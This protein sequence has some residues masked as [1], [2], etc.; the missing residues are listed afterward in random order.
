V[1]VAEE[2]IEQAGGVVGREAAAVEELGEI[3]RQAKEAAYGGAPGKIAAT[4]Q[5][6]ASAISFGASDVALRSAGGGDVA[7][8]L[9]ETNPGYRLAGEA[10]GSLLG[11]GAKIGGAVAK[12]V[13]GITGKLVGA[14]TEGYLQGA[15]SGVSKTFLAEDDITAERLLGNVSSNALLGGGI[16]VGTATAGLGVEKLLRSARKGAAAVEARAGKAAAGDPTALKATAADDILSYHSTAREDGRWLIADADPKAKAALTKADRTLRGIGDTPDSFRA[17]PGQA[18][19]ALEKEE[20]ALTKIRDTRE[21]GLAKLADE[22][23]AIGAEVRLDLETMPTGAAETTFTGKTAQRYGAWAD[24]RVKGK[25]PQVKVTR[26][27]AAQFANAI[28]AGEVQGARAQAYAKLDDSIAR[29]QGL[30]TQLAE[31]VKPAAVVK[32][33]F[34]EKAVSGTIF[35]A[36][37]GAIPAIPFGAVVAPAI[38]AKVS[39][40][41]T[42]LLFRRAGGAVGSAAAGTAKALDVLMGAAEQVNK[43]A[44]PLSSKVLTSVR[45]GEEER[46]GPGRPKKDAVA[47]T[48]K[49]DREQLASAFRAREKELRSQVA[50]GP[51]GVTR[52][53]P[54]ARLKVGEHLMPIKQVQPKLADMVETVAARRVEF[55]ASKLPKRPDYLAMQFGPD[56]WRPSSLEMR[57][58]ARYVAAAEGP[59]AV[60]DRLAAGRLSPEDAE[61]Y[62]AIYPERFEALKLDVIKR[63]PELQKQ[64]PF[65]KRVALSMFTG[66]PLVPALRPE[67]LRVLQGGYTEEPGTDGGMNAPAANPAFGSVSREQPTPAQSRGGG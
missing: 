20:I 30:R 67:I 23:V 42:D 10:V 65:D 22:D 35:G 4:A 60:E 9:A 40:A 15:G 14:G 18:A 34:L 25:T 52:M 13:G 29:V 44:V 41:I 37:V 51:D 43:V 64:L 38:G 33:S 66:V 17:S 28:E 36:T 53:T 46:R 62:R 50:V 57:R 8:G 49:G 2:D 59:G 48:P 63:M 12:K 3:D 32:E 11:P 56:A 58:F 1:E 54:A 6:A 19:K 7:R 21:S 45:F 39:S 16:G 55:L 26:E 61:A 24:V 5:G 47:V 31:A 27:S